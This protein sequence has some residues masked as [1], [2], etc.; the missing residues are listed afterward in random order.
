MRAVAGITL[1]RD[2]LLTHK[3]LDP[4]GDLMGEGQISGCFK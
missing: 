2:H 3:G 4:G 1:K